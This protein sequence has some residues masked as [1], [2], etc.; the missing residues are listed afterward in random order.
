[1]NVSPS[2]AQT[3]TLKQKKA[4]H[5]FLQSLTSKVISQNNDKEHLF[6]AAARWILFPIAAEI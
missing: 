5:N 6:F 4:S 2:D 3:L 1:M